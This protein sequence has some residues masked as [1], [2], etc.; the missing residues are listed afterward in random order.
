MRELHTSFYKYGN[1]Y[2]A[3][4]TGQPTDRVM[5]GV[6]QSRKEAHNS[7]QETPVSSVGT[8]CGEQAAIRWARGADWLDPKVKLQRIK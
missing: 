8:D 1:E 2:V 4:V 6:G 3:V 7:L 5:I